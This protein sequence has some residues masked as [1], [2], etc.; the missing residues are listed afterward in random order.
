M[1]VNTR[2]YFAVYSVEL[3]PEELTARIG[4][5]PTSVMTKAA[6]RAN[7][8]RPATNAWKLDSGLD[9]HAPVWDHL[10]ALCALVTPVTARIAELCQGEP[11][12]SLAIV[13]K[14]LPAVGEARLGLWLD[15]PWLAILWQTGAGLDVDEYDYTSE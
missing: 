9:S 14:F 10:Q 12:A 4:L 13:R 6:R 7:P 15:E 11:T 3:S 5:T 1:R 2:A 8:P